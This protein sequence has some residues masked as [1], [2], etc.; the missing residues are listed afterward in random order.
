MK[1]TTREPKELI[2]AESAILQ[3]LNDC[4]QEAKTEKDYNKRQKLEKWAEAI[5][6]YISIQR[7]Y[8]RLM[9]LKAANLQVMVQTYQS[10]NKDGDTLT[11]IMHEK[12]EQLAA[13]KNRF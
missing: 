4:S 5:A 6:E 10:L 7:D 2:I 12:Y 3:V 8:A 1:T 13:R 9:K 11:T